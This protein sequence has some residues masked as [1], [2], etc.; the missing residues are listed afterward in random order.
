M[1][2]FLKYI[3]VFAP[4]MTNAQ[5]F[6]FNLQKEKYE[7]IP[8][9]EIIPITPYFVQ[10]MWM[11]EGKNT[12]VATLLGPCLLKTTMNNNNIQIHESTGY[13]YTNELCF[14]V[15]VDKPI[16]FNLKIRKPGWAKSFTCNKPY[17]L[18]SGYIVIDKTFNKNEKIL[19]KFEACI[20]IHQDSN[21]DKYFTYGGLL[22]AY[23]FEYTE[24]KGRI[25]SPTLSDY[26]YVPKEKK[27]F[28]MIE[29]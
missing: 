19:L 29:Y 15:I 5:S 21:S 26:Y 24:L 23:P 28:K 25:Y 17:T 3:F 12:L 20:E 2:P 1:N 18:E 22:Y 27:E 14:K 13:P 6:N 11:K 4:M 10:N 9:G 8:F 7:N 16:N